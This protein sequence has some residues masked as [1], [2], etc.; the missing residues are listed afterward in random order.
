MID[1]EMRGRVVVDAWDH[2]A[3]YMRWFYRV[4]HPIVCPVQTAEEPP[5]PPNLE[6]LIAEQ[7]ANNVPDALE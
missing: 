2:E 4:S 7:E 6:V 5:R 3:G 1:E